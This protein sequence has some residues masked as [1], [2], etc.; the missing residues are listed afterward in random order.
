MSPEQTSPLLALAKSGDRTAFDAIAEPHRREL[1]L[2]CYR[3]LGTLQDAEDAVQE[4]LL[5]AW[6]GIERFHGKASFRNWLYRIA[7]NTCLNALA[8]SATKRRVMPEMEGPPTLQLPPREP[9]LDVAWLEPYPDEWLEGIPDEAPGPEVRYEQREAIHLA[10]VAVIQTL[11]PRQRAAL[12]L[13]D[14]LGWSAAESARLL[15]A[16]VA[17]VNSALQRARATIE[18]HRPAWSQRDSRTTPNE[19]QRA[20]LSRYV[21]SW[22]RADVEGFVQVLKEDVT[23]TMP[24][25]REWYRG[26]DAVRTFFAFTANPGGHAPFRLVRTEANGQIAYA[27]YSRWRSPEWRAH[28]IQLVE[29]D[30]SGVGK[31]VSFVTPALFAKFGLPDALTDGDL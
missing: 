5:R 24:P 18:K 14:V 2:H 3:M 25:W 7:T 4:S 13:Q 23:I 28:S 10:F 12:L 8:S 11:P 17:S 29:L 27:F 22:E 21:R 31:M 9:A 16:T 15:D 30:N 20:L 19:Q 1:Q 26:R 6:R